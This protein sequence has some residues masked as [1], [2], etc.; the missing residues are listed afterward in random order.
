M[1]QRV[2]YGFHATWV[3]DADAERAADQC[4][5]P[6]PAPAEHPALQPAEH[7]RVDQDADDEDDD[8]RR[9]HALGV[10]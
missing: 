7:Q 3:A 6:R 4:W 10:G 8:H 2:P 9:H 5:A 1:P